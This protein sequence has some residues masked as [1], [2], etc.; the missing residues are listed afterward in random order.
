MRKITII[1]Y[2]IGVIFALVLFSFLIEAISLNSAI[3]KVSSE[4]PVQNK[5][6]E[7][8]SN[9]PLSPWGKDP[10]IN[11]F[12]NLEN[13]SIEYRESHV[14][15]VLLAMKWWEND[16]NHNLSYKVNLTM[17]NNSNDANIIIKW[18]ETLY[19]GRK[20]RGHTNIE[21]TKTCDPLNPP[22]IQCTIIVLGNLSY[23]ENLYVIKHELGHAL[24][25][26]HSFN[27]SDFFILFF[28]NLFNFNSE[29]QFG[30]SEIMFDGSLYDRVIIY[31]S[32]ITLEIVNYIFI[33][34]ILIFILL[35]YYIF[36][37]KRQR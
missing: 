33:T 21:E 15:E 29:Y 32:M 34:I 10:R 2:I 11:V 27:N 19:G 16:K 4:F 28:I 6:T 7:K 5:I 18:N 26:K 24:G 30:R 3:N 17:I 37:Q 1:C 9:K 23:D 13:V 22:F 25:L 8:D 35:L 14:Y 31:Q 12:I 20:N 36:K